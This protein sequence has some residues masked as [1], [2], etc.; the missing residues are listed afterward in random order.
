MLTKNIFLYNYPY[1][2][3]Y[4]KI[5]IKYDFF[6]DYLVIFVDSCCL[7]NYAIKH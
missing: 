5:L 3:C 4:K 1:C 7:K 6:V 2:Y